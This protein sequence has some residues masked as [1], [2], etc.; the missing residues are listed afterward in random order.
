MIPSG[1]M[2]DFSRYPVLANSDGI[3]FSTSAVFDVRYYYGGSFFGPIT[4]VGPSDSGSGSV[5][6]DSRLQPVPGPLPLFGAAA[7]YSW[8]RGPRRRIAAEA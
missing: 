4:N 8:S 5:I 6:L 1:E 7:A 3:S 2:V